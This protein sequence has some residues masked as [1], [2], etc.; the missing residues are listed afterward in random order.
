MLII[1]CQIDHAIRAISWFINAEI[2][3]NYF[4]PYTSH[5]FHPK[6]W[7]SPK[8]IS[9]N[10]AIIANCISLSTGVL[11]QFQTLSTLPGI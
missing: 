11:Y 1:S 9:F 4:Y 5:P 10:H 7:T 2:M 3:N 8:K 6:Y